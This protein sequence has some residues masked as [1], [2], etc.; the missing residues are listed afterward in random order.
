LITTHGGACQ[1]I[2]QRSLIKVGKIGLAIDAAIA[3]L[4]DAYDLTIAYQS[5][6]FDGKRSKSSIAQAIR[7]AAVNGDI[8]S[9]L[10]LDIAF[11]FCTLS[12]LEKLQFKDQLLFGTPKEKDQSRTFLLIVA[13]ALES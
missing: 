4:G 5:G 8:L 13:E 1:L 11:C 10:Q 6:Y 7:D 2:G 12:Y 3:A 9:N